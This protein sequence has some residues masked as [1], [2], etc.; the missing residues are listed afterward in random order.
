MKILPRD[1][2]FLTPPEVSRRYRVKPEKIVLLIRA[3][4]LRAIDT[5][6]PGSRRP[7]FRVPVEALAEFEQRRAVAQVQPVRR[8]KRRRRLPLEEFV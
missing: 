7:R 6:K 2:K 1:A 4:V 8:K 5:A 3:G